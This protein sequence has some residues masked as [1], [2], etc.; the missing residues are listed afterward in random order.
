MTHAI[1]GYVSADW[2]PHQDA[3]SMHA[4]RM[5]RDNLERAVETPGRGRARR[6]M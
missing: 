1:E 5:I 6:N 4:L 3:R 2:S